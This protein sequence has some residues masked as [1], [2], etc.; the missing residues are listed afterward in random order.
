MSTMRDDSEANKTRNCCI[1]VSGISTAITGIFFITLVVVPLLSYFNYDE[2]NCS[3]SNIT[4]PTTI[5]TSANDEG[6]MEC[7]CGKYC[8]AWTPCINVYL[9]INNNTHKLIDGSTWNI[10]DSSEICSFYN[11]SC[12]EGENIIM[13]QQFIN[14]AEEIAH[15]Y[16]TNETLTCYVNNN[17]GDVYLSDVIPLNII[18]PL[19][20]FFGIF[21]II[22]IL[23]IIKKK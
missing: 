19:S 5:P 13:I 6:W 8:T 17:N 7:D 20:V 21:I 10:G 18:I 15:Q 9:D 12:P 14:W 22:F 2:I 16:H 23:F 11:S 1:C 3:V 4:Y